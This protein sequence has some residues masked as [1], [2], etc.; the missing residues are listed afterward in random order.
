MKRVGQALET[1]ML[2]DGLF[3]AHEDALIVV[4]GDFN[5]NLDEVPVEGAVAALK[6]N[7]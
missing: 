3:D 4:C 7:A 6:V 5:A 2:I 1:R